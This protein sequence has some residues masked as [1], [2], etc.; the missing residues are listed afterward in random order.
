MESEHEPYGT[1]TLIGVTNQ[2]GRPSAKAPAR[3]KVKKPASHGSSTT[4]AERDVMDSP[5]H[6]AIDHHFDR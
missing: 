6:A 3:T 1:P 4:T 5:V 2:L